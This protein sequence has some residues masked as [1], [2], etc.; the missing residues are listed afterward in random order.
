MATSTIKHS[1]MR[2]SNITDLALYSNKSTGWVIIASGIDKNNK[3][4]Y[5]GFDANTGIY[6][7]YDN[8]MQWIINPTDIRR[9]YG[10]QI[11]IYSDSWGADYHGSLGADYIST[12]TGKTVHIVPDPGGTLSRIYTTK[13]DSYNADIYIISAGLN[14]VGLNT[15]ISSFVS[16]IRTFVTAIKNVNANAEIY[17]ITPPMMRTTTVHDY[18]YPLEL[19]RIAIYRM[20]PIC[21]YNVINSLKWTDVG[22]ENDK[23]HPLVADAPKIAK[24]II[25]ALN[26]FGDEETHIMDYSKVTT[27]FNNELYY[28]CENGQLYVRCNALT[29]TV[30][31]N[32]N[33]EITL[34]NLSGTDLSPMETTVMA[35]TVDPIF[36]LHN[37][38]GATL[39]FFKSGMQSGDQL[40]ISAA[41]FPIGL[42]ATL[43]TT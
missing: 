11:A 15:T 17:F 3:D 23:T 7:N 27:I 42:E 43:F 35:G 36:I 1:I 4:F 14:D 18:L 20:A 22:L 39:R 12:Y 30:D 31:S 10:K 6:C 37:H 33:A 25:T 26:N 24:H 28:V 9:I 41:Q 38:N 16:S 32:G 29:L 2:I 5:I 40:Y 34:P 21:G 8:T 19:Y 13:W